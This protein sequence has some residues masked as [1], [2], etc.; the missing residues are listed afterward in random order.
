M[1]V[2]G[3]KSETS[4][5]SHTGYTDQSIKSRMS[6]TISDSLCICIQSKKSKP[7]KENVG[8]NITTIIPTE[9]TVDFDMIKVTFK[10]L[11]NA[12]MNGS[13]TSLQDDTDFEDIMKMINTQDMTLS[14]PKAITQPPMQNHNQPIAP[15]M[16]VQYHRQPVINQ[17]IQN[18]L[19][20][21]LVQMFSGCSNVTIN[22]NFH[23]NK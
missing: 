8:S 5:K 2:T 18:Q 16:P 7:D 9:V 19:M 23:S 20:S 10:S 17:M 21:F 14:P 22:Y 13:M 15:Q 11:S 12:Q 6:D 1:S 3:H 4:L